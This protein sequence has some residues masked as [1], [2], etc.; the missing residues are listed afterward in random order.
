MIGCRY[1]SLCCQHL[2]NVRQV[3]G[4]RIDEQGN[5]LA[6]ACLD[7]NG[8][9][10]WFYRQFA[11]ILYPVLPEAESS[12]SS[13]PSNLMTCLSGG[14]PISSAITSL[15]SRTL[16]EGST[17]NRIFLVLPPG[18]PPRWQS[19]WLPRHWILPRRARLAN[20]THFHHEFRSHNSVPCLL[21]KGPQRYEQRLR[22]TE[23]GTE[24]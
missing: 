23:I 8:D 10:A 22:T 17:F 11:S 13:L 3:I 9:F 7:R 24:E 4:V 16:S 18:F 5:I 21:S 14:N 1:A 6:V 2:F 15:I 12:G 19:A 20:S